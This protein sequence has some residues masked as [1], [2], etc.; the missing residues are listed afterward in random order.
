[1]LVDEVANRRDP[2]RESTGEAA[3]TPAGGGD[4]LTGPLPVET[5][6][7]MRVQETEGLARSAL[8]IRADALDRIVN[9]S[10][11]VGIARTRA[12]AEVR[13]L[14]TYMRELADNVIR[15]RGQLRDLEI[16]AESQL[17]ST[18]TMGSGAEQ[19]FDPLEFD[20][21]TRFQELTRMMAESLSD[22]TVVQQSIHRN[23]DE[24]SAALS[25][26]AL[27]S[28]DLQQELMRVRMVP[29]S[30]IAERLHRVVRQS[31]KELGKRANLDIH[32]LHAEVD[33]V[34]LERITAPLEHLLRNAVTH[35]LESPE[36]RAAAGKAAIG[37]VSIE[38]MQENNEIVLTHR[39]DGAGI[40]PARI[41]AKAIAGGFFSETRE[42]S[43]AE[44]LE[45]IFQPGFST[46]AQVTQLAGRGVG[47]DV[48]RSEV[49]A[50]G[51][52]VAVSSAVGKGATFTLH[53]PLT[54]SV[55]RALLVKA[56][57]HTFA[58]P[59]GMVE[60]VLLLGHA[61]IAEAGESG[62]VAWRGSHVA[63]RYLP[64]LF[65][66]PAA[67]PEARKRY[68]VLVL[69]AGTETMA[70]VVDTV[71]AS[72]DIVLKNLGPQ[73]TRLSGVIGASILPGGDI[74]LLLNPF[75]LRDTGA[76]AFE[77]L[78]TAAP[79]ETPHELVSVMVVDDSITVR[80]VTHRLLSKQ[81]YEVVTARDGVE[82]LERLRE[83]RPAVM[84]VD[85]EMPRMDGFELTRLVRSS[86]TLHDI[87]IIMI[88]SRAADKHREV[89]HEIGVN[90]FLGKPYSEQELLRHVQSFTRKAA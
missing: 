3:E 80:R 44:L 6:G 54:L 32:G 65:G 61:E 87:P 56:G 8:R 60:E 10:G 83:S 36:A 45:L 1:L 17:Q 62:T 40:E 46:A 51:G 5:T 77:A 49:K 27:L 79:Q 75:Q 89:A 53:L 72:R 34:V 48:V 84:L 9:Q 39:D 52:R 14:K 64:R 69:K 25:A 26:Q 58:L 11:E 55:T 86:S 2:G 90:V 78:P 76:A 88:T 67:T 33:R 50:L 63:L 70:V 23:V 18:T 38:V 29:F 85:I 66:A 31:A 21:Y 74:A 71:V 47:L 59:A 57:A 73:L 30:S 81:G 82:A 19:S 35:G 13:A 7:P 15:L 43:E 12:E 28:R 20:R 24:V 16:H 22:V 4:E 41:R 37:E 68:P 42:P